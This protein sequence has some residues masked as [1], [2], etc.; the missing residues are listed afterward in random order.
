MPHACVPI[1]PGHGFDP[2]GCGEFCTTVHWFSVNGK[3]H[4]RALGP[5]PGSN[6]GC[7]DAVLEGGM[8]NDKGAW[9]LGR[10]GWCN[11]RD[12]KPWVIDITQQLAPAGQGNELRYAGLFNGTQP[13]PE[14]KTGSIMLSANLVLW[15]AQ[16]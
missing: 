1:P 8:P 14:Q 11:G 16:T 12:V 13:L 2:F 6:Y 4:S 9:M 5:R 10:A 7:A 3:L 15:E